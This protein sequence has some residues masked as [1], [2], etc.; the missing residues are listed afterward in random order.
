MTCHMTI[1]YLF[2]NDNVPLLPQ[3]GLITQQNQF[4]FMFEKHRKIIIKINKNNSLIKISAAK[5]NRYSF[6]LIAIETTIKQEDSN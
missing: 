5:D 6:M 1:C 4:T 3:S 2:L